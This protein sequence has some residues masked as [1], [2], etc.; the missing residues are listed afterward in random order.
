MRRFEGPREWGR[1]V[2]GLLNDSG[3]SMVVLL[4]CSGEGEVDLEEGW[5]EDV[6]RKLLQVAVEGVGMKQLEDWSRQE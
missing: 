4:F 6:A 1:G 2:G 3:V 5:V